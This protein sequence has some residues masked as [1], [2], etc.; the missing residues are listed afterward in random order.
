MTV[1]PVFSKSGKGLNSTFKKSNRKTQQKRRKVL[2]KIPKLQTC[3]R[4]GKIPNAHQSYWILYKP[5]GPWSRRLSPVSVVLS[6]WESLTPSGWDTN[7]SQVSSQ[8]MLVLIY[9]P[10]KDG[11]GG[12]GGHTNIQIS[13]EPGSNQWLSGRKA[14]ILPSAPTMPA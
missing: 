2:H 10:R 11:L 14:E 3:L 7:P 13:A 12:K 1:N 4:S 9:L 6:G 8:Q 5:S